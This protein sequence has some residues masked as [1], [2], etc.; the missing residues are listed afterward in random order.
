MK[1]LVTGASS[2]IGKSIAELLARKGNIVCGIGQR[3]K[4]SFSLKEEQRKNLFYK[5]CNVA[6][7]SDVLRLKKKLNKKGFSPD[8]IILSA[9]IYPDDIHPQYNS[10][11]FRQTFETNLFGSMNFVEA[12]LPEFLAKRHGHFITLSSIAA[13]RPNIRGISYPSSKAALSLA[14]RGLDMQYRRKNVPFSVVYL[15][16][17]ETAMWEGKKSFIVAKPQVIAKKVISAMKSRKQVYYLPF[18]ST[19]LAR[20]SLMIP[21]KLYVALTQLFLK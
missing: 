20:A 6:S 10:D 14:F 15:G 7:S 1:V 9:G 3:S 16:P 4:V 8:T 19:L 12:Y 13:F 11:I 5:R 18:L 21:D 17:V 2:G